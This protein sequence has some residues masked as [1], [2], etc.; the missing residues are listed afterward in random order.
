MIFFFDQ[1][2][3][4]FSSIDDCFCCSKMKSEAYGSRLLLLKLLCSSFHLYCIAVCFLIL[5]VL[6]LLIRF[7]FTFT[8]VRTKELWVKKSSRNRMTAKLRKM[9]GEK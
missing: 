9:G 7:L 1:K 3:R 5:L 2:I 4:V 6:L 8:A